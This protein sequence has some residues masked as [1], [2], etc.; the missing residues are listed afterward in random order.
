MLTAKVQQ[1]ERNRVAGLTGVAGVIAKPFDA[2]RLAAD[3]SALLGWD[4]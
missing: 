4:A 3:V 2:M 1:A